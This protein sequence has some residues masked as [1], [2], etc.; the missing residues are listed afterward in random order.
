MQ[1]LI[2]S[3]FLG[4]ATVLGITCALL[5]MSAAWVIARP[6]RA[7][8]VLVAL[9]AAYFL[10]ALS[11]GHV[12]GNAVDAD[13]KADRYAG[14]SRHE[15]Y[16]FSTSPVA[17]APPSIELSRLVPAALFGLGA[18]VSLARAASAFQAERKFSKAARA[19]LLALERQKTDVGDHMPSDRPL[20][21]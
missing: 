2:S 20:L 4:A 19:D 3:L 15:E 18:L 9:S 14:T 17:R 13:I 1:F 6:I 7:F 10:A 8:L 21:L 16:A 11:E 12:V 5:T